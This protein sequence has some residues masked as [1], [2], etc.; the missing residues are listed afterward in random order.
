MLNDIRINPTISFDTVGALYISGWVLT[1]YLLDCPQRADL[2]LL[3][4]PER[5]H[6]LP[7][8][9]RLAAGGNWIRT[10]GPNCNGE[11]RS[12]RQQTMSVGRSQAAGDQT[13]ATRFRPLEL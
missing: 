5:F 11:S 6:F 13:I 4:Q 9:F 1:S 10:P 12:G 3:L 8:V 7:R 2:S